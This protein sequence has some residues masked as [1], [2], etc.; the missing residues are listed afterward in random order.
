MSWFRKH[1]AKEIA[2][3]VAE[4]A[5]RWERAAEAA[6]LADLITKAQTGARIREASAADLTGSDFSSAAGF[7]FQQ[8]TGFEFQQPTNFETTSFEPNGRS[9][10]TPF[11]P[12][13]W[14]ATPWPNG[15]LKRGRQ[16]NDQTDR[17]LTSARVVPNVR[18]P[19]QKE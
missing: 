8:P 18:T 10:Q 2:R 4:K 1:S 3:N 15:C 13:S 16:E 17:L 14:P 19:R 7:E 9:I 11:P 12:C 6:R 5:E